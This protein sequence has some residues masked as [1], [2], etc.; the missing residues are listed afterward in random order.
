MYKNNLKN[1]GQFF[2]C[3]MPCM[4]THR[5]RSVE[6]SHV[7]R[8]WTLCRGDME[9][10]QFARE[11][12]RIEN[13]KSDNLAMEREDAVAAVKG[14]DVVLDT[15]R[16]KYIPSAAYK[17]SV[18]ENA[19][20]GWKLNNLDAERRKAIDDNQNF[21]TYK[22]IAHYHSG[23]SGRVATKQEAIDYCES[24]GLEL[25]STEELKSHRICDYQWVSDKPRRSVLRD[26]ID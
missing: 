21:V 2:F 13:W 14:N 6:N 25:C 11:R 22:D 16:N 18:E 4:H 23:R 15:E 26:A 5:L 7:P 3:R 24:K 19:V 10:K 17:L 1:Y 20:L 12:E 9:I 8:C